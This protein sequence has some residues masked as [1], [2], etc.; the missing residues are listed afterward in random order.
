M[1]VEKV[2]SRWFHVMVLFGSILSLLVF[3]LYVAGVFPFGVAPEKSAE[4]WNAASGE[5]LAH[6]GLEFDSL[7]FVKADNGYMLSLAA[8]GLLAST[9]LPTLLAL[10]IAWLKRKDYLYSS[11]AFLVSV[12]LSVAIFGRFS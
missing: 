1:S 8:L 10:S 12:V 3:A 4:A 6:G 9:A 11:M 2:A 5:F 7:W